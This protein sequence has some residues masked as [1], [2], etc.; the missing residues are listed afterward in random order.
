MKV[1]T[2]SE[3]EKKRKRKNDLVAYSFLAPNFIGFAVFT[4][5]PIVV[6]VYMAFCQWDGSNPA[7][8]VGFDNFV[9]LAKDEFFLNALLN[10]LLYCLGTVPITMIVALGLAILLNQKIKGRGFI[11]AVACFPYV[12]SIIAVTTVWRMLFHPS[13][14]PVNSILFDL[15]QSD[16]LPQWFSGRLIIVSYILFSLW[17]SMGYY[18]VIYLAGLQG[19]SNDLYEASE[20]D[21]AGRWQKFRYVTWPQ[22]RPTTFFV[23][24][25]LT[26]GCFKIY[27]TAVLLSGTNNMS[28][29]S[30]VL[31]SFIYSKAFT[32][33]D[34]GYASAAAI[35]LFLIVLA[36]TLVQFKNESKFSND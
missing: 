2:L 31:V 5:V 25:I 27:D 24:I 30:M 12:S 34:L 7:K 26:I 3:K 20:L 29:S 32:N 6:A 33:W 36:V 13:K 14:G 11:R 9:N 8:F 22:L 23:V 15:F 16:A 17:K 35:C 28:T 10:T 18:M 21:G 4:L 1:Q 19:I